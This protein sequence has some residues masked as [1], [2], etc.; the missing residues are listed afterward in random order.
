MADTIQV[1]YKVMEDGSLKAIGRDAEKA[2]K[3]TDKATKSA[4]KYSKKNKGV[5]QAT[6]NSTKAFSKMTT[7]IQGGLVPAY[8][9]LAANVFALT[10]VFGTLSRMDAVAKL[11][12]GLEFT[13]RSAGR[14]LKMVADGLKEI[15]GN[16]VSAEQAMRTTAVGIS[17]G[18]S[19]SQMKGLAEVAKG[20]SLALG[21]DMADAMD[22]LTRGAAKLEPEILDELGIIVRLD[23]AVDAYAKKHNKATS[24]L[25]Q[26]ERRQAFTNAI[27]EDGRQK[28]AGITDAMDPSA[29]SKL[30]A[31][32]SDLTKTVIG[33]LNTALNPLVDFFAG[34]PA[35]LAGVAAVF[36]GGMVNQLIGGLQGIASGAAEAAERTEDHA[37]AA[38]KGIKPHEK[39]GKAFNEVAKGTDRGDKALKRMLKSVNMSINMTSKDVEKLKIAT[40]ARNALT[41]EIFRQELAETKRRLAGSL[42]TLQ[43]F[44]AAEAFRHLGRELTVLRTQTLAA[45][46][47]QSFLNKMF[48]LGSGFATG[49]AASIRLV[50]AAFLSFLPYIGLAV[51]AFTLLMPYF[52]KEETGLDRTIKKNTE[53]FEEFTNVIDQY[54][55]AVEKAASESQTWKATIKPLGGMANETA[56]GLFDIT[57]AIK[58]G[59]QEQKQ[60]ALVAMQLARAQVSLA[61]QP[62]GAPLSGSEIADR[63]RDREN[64][65]NNFKDA[66]EKYDKLVGAEL[67]A[68]DQA[69]KNALEGGAA[70]AGAL[71]LMK[72]KL[73]EKQG[74]GENVSEALG[75]V[76]QAQKELTTATEK[77]IA[78]PTI[79]GIN[80]FG[81]AVKTTGERADASVAAFENFKNFVSQLQGTVGDN[82]RV[83]GVFADRINILNKAQLELDAIA[84]GGSLSTVNEE[85]QKALTALEVTPEVLESYERLQGGVVILSSYLEETDKT[86]K[87]VWKNAADA[88]EKYQKALKDV[89]EEQRK[90]IEEAEGLAKKEIYTRNQSLSMAKAQLKN[91]D[92]IYQN[93]L[94]QVALETDLENRKRLEKELNKLLEKRLKLIMKIGEKRADAASNAGMG[95]AASGAM[96]ETASRTAINT[97]YDADIAVAKGKGASDEEIAALEKARDAELNLATAKA[98]RASIPGIA[99]ELSAISEENDMLSAAMTGI[100][101]MA[102]AW[103]LATET[104]T[105]ANASMVAKINAGLGAL[106]ATLTAIGNFQKAKSEARIRQIDREIEAEKK[107]DGASEAS[108]AK[109]SKLEKKKEAEKRKAFEKDKKMKIAQ[110]II[111]GLQGA[112][113]AY[114]SL[115]IIPIIGPALGAAAAAAVLSM[116]ADS[117]SAIKATQYQGGGSVGGATKISAG[118]GRSN[119]VDLANANN[120]SGEQA[121]MR[122]AEGR[123][124][125]GD[126]KPAFAGYKHRQA[127]GYVVGEQGPE[128]FMPETPGEI[129][130]AGQQTGGTTNVNFS[131]NA[132]DAT[133]VQELLEVQKGN[134][135]AMIRQAANE[136]GEDFLEMVREDSL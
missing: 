112:I 14:N 55:K 52:K 65:I 132:V 121:Y 103:T 66:K 88:L 98:A 6:S 89:N 22:R 27:L 124:K 57:A 36:G 30:A 100:N 7:G 83:F 18:F 49:F 45:A 111:G 110:T 95:A 94:K 58:S 101:N 20:A 73:L 85:A 54:T 118:G 90:L 35:A 19:E 131:I 26:F 77:F 84:K 28:F 3:G 42:G 126:F 130:P 123:G 72:N 86:G 134:I 32:F 74:E 12:E 135:I 40:K 37:K 104:M 1:T 44:G 91:S 113:A 129:I 47:G 46:S 59:V 70:L 25:T 11:E 75:A 41:K 79:D 128:V 21:R 2:A 43:T 105:D 106:K 5:A 16:A 108:R 136:H 4:D 48:I 122:G 23:D 127:G 92:G 64:A 56:Q 33:G 69:I 67:T 31:A 17:A 76:T 87:R 78:N 102:T 50:G 120:A 29:Y 13:G 71:E 114:T 39:M 107:K 115:A 10:A 61:S 125:M 8:A 24:A 119:Q 62:A 97:R 9:T 15:T 81:D 34:A 93:M 63:V 38:L 133:G 80:E 96:I 109:I 117:V 60:A 82:S 53:R 68:N 51:T 116:T 99:E